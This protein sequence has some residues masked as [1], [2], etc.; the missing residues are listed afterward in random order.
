MTRMSDAQAAIADVKE[1]GLGAPDT[2]LS[3]GESDRLPGDDP[4][5]IEYVDG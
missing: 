5:R 1:R 2:G 4:R 3:R